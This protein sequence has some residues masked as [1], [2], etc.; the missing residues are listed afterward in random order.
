M[1]GKDHWTRASCLG[2]PLSRWLLC[3]QWKLSFLS[4]LDINETLYRLGLGSSNIAQLFKT[5]SG[6]WPKEV[7]SLFILRSSKCVAAVSSFRR[8]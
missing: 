6:R 1:S 7:N 4:F 5:W 3:I 2:P 8:L